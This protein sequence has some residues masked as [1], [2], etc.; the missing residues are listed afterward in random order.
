[1]DSKRVRSRW[2]I[3]G[4][5]KNKKKKRNRKKKNR[6][7]RIRRTQNLYIFSFFNLGRLFD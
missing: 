2:M 7:E 5:L 4:H 6:G 3:G 1:L